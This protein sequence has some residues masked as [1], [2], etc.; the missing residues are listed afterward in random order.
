MDINGNTV[1]DFRVDLDVYL[2]QLEDKYD[3]NLNL[4]TITYDEDE[5]S[6]RLTVQNRG[7]DFDLKNWCAHYWKEGFDAK[8]YG[9]VFEDDGKLFK[10]I[11]INRRRKN[12][13]IVT[14]RLSDHKPVAYKT[15]KV[16]SALAEYGR[17]KKVGKE[18]VN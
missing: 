9:R 1:D 3:I 13:P 12:Y 6:A 8:D 15:M 4:G 14:E 11:G 17:E 10:I 18:N 7:V 16:H 5:F 2:K